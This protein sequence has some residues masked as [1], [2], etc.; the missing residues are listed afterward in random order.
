MADLL[1]S[2]EKSQG[3][4]QNA[5]AAQMIKVMQQFTGGKRGGGGGSADL[6]K[7]KSKAKLGVDPVTSKLLVTGPHH[8]YKQVLKRVELLDVPFPPPAVEIMEDVGITPAQLS[9]MKA[10]FGDKLQLLDGTTGEPME[11]SSST[12]GTAKK[13]SSTG[14]NAAAAQQQEMIKRMTEGISRARQ[15]QQSRGGGNTRGGGTRGGG[16]RGG[17]TRGG[18]GR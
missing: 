17:G 11:G 13:A 1:D 16:T 9:T 2:G 18:R 3:G 8:I 10:I 7:E 15:Q 14:G 5:E 6:E 12:S 4:G